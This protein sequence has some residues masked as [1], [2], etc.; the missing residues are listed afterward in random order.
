MYRPP[1]Q[2]LSLG[3]VVEL[4]RRFIIGYERY[5]DEPRVIALKAKVQ[6]YNKLLA[7][8]GLRDHQVSTVVNYSATLRLNLVLPSGR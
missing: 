1:G 5:K 8:M 7:Y 2:Q 4:N 3:Q 6:R